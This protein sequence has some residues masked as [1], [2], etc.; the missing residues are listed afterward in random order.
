M[1]LSKKV[2]AAIALISALSFAFA[3]DETSVENEYLTDV[4]GDIITTLAESDD[5]ENKLVALQ[6]LE[7]AIEEGNTSPAVIAALDHLAGEGINTQSRTN[8]RLT[9]NFSSVR[10]EACLLLAKVPSEHSKNTLI[11]IALNDNEPMV[12]AAAVQSLGKIGINNNDETVE[13]IAFANRKN[14]T[15]NPTSSLAMEV[16]NAYEALAETTENKKS[17]ID[18]VARISTDYHYVTPVRQKAYR[19]LK[20]LSQESKKDSSSKKDD[21][22]NKAN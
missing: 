19:L 12:M 10:R 21:S 11:N 3:Q 4:D 14:Q 13:A 22:A 6:Y 15:L 9:N 2:L 17:M 20:K 5:F 7:S 8:G 18:S 16:L 1:K